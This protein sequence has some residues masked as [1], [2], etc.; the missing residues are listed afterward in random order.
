MSLLLDLTWLSTVLNQTERTVLSQTIGRGFFLFTVLWYF[1]GAFSF[2][3]GGQLQQ[4]FWLL[5]PRL[6]TCRACGGRVRALNIHWCACDRLDNNVKTPLRI[7]HFSFSF[8]QNEKE[9]NE[10]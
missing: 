2:F 8:D 7:E 9:S 4:Q 6:M 5:K 3:V 10:L 1:S